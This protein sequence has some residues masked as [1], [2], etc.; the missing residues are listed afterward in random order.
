MPADP[1]PRFLGWRSLAAVYAPAALFST[2]QGAVLPVLPLTARD[3]G[4]SVAASAFLV[5][6]LG[7]G[8]VAGALPAGAM[9]ARVG[10]RRAMLFS[11]LVSGAALTGA[12]L[13][14]DE[15]V[16]AACVL[17]LGL[18]AAIWSLARQSFLTAAAPPHLRA[19]ALSTL[20]GVGRIG[21]FVGPFLGAAG[22]A[23]WGV[24]GSYVVAGVAVVLAAAVVL[25]LPD[26]EVAEHH[27]GPAPTLREVFRSHAH[28]LATLGVSALAVQ[29]VRQSRQT[30]LPLWCEHLGLDATTTSLVAGV[31]GAVDML[32]F[33]PAGSVMDRVGRAAVGV[34]SMLVLAVGHVLLPFSHTAWTVALVGVVMGFGNGMGAGLV[35]TLGA[36]VAPPGGRAVFLGAWRLVTDTGAASGP[37]LVG[38]LAGAGS[39][40]VATGGVAVLAVAAAGGLFRFV[41]RRA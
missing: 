1:A 37:L 23:V 13:A 21:T 19:R 35:M 22:S 10:E 17:A 39:L 24:R 32:L 4:A 8:Q 36:D 41:P 14:P 26:P 12:V 15:T 16:L 3:L 33:Y 2:S 18:A 30:V 27:P 25:T 6:L 9:V 11:A 38:A 28:V 7:I 34:P 31:S 29:A 40:V 20:G 5:A